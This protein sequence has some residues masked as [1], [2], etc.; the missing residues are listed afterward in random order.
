M[1]QRVTYNDNGYV[2][3]GV[4]VLLALGLLLSVGMV[5]S[6][7]TNAKT[8]VL[9]RTQADNYYEVE[10]TLA[11]VV[12]WL[13]TN[14]KSLVTPFSSANFNNN[15]DLGSPTSGDNEGQHFDV[16]TMVKMKGTN[17]S[18]M[19]SNNAYFGTSAFPSA[20]HID[21]G[22]SFDAI[23]AFDT[24]D[25]GGA[26]ARI[27]LVWARETDG[28]YEPVFRVDVMTGNNPDRGVHSYSYVYSTLVT[29]N[30][31]LNFYGRDFLTTQTPNNDCYS[32]QYTNSAGVW[33]G[34]AQ[35][36][37]CG[38]GSNGMINV[39]SKINGTAKSLIDPGISLNSP[40]GD[41]SGT[42]CEGGG[43]H[44]YSLPPLGAWLSYCATH[45]G[46]LSIGADT[47]LA[48]GGCWQDVSIANKN[49]LF[50]ADTTAPYYF[51]SLDFGPNAAE[52][53]FGPGGVIPPGDTVTVYVEAI[54]N[55]HING[56]T[57]YN[58]SNAP[59]Q[60][61]I[62]Y[63]GATELKLNGTA[64]IN[65][66]I[67]ASNAPVVVNGNFNMYGGIWSTSLDVKGNARLYA[68]ESVGGVPVLSDMNFALKKTSQRYR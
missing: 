25:L 44:G 35:R 54:N 31:T 12:A 15:F 27:I 10:E 13:Q 47:T 55:D 63:L 32:L 2:L 21:T 42:L 36:S 37:N 56:N 8:R 61:E 66:M 11:N 20:E 52:V 43:C 17:D 26:N 45:N 14:S 58:A 29:S 57:F 24:A 65:A 5:N 6:A 23:T 46:D 39:S 4:M 34:G 40:G 59:H 9:V 67:T 38:V 28:N 41:V 48:T 64:D 3:L 68:D 30:S 33:S 50:L 53:Q 1:K 19:L 16:P 22:A 7:A 62:F 60:V 18:V 49:T 51:R